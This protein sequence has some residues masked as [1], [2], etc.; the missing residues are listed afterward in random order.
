M[1]GIC[2]RDFLE[3]AATGAAA[4]ALPGV[5]AALDGC[6]GSARRPPN[7][8]FILIDDMGW[9]DL[10]SYGSDLYETPNIDRLASQGMRFTNAYAASAV[11]SPTRASIMTGKYPARLDITD[12]IGGS[13][14]GRLLPAE[15]QHELPLEEVTIAEAFQNAGYTTGYIGKW[16]LGSDGYHPEDQGFGLNIGGHDAGQPSS[17]FWPYRRDPDI[18]AYWDVPD[19]EDGI[20]GEYLTDRLTREAVRFIEDNR[21]HPFLLYLAHYAV[22]T[23]IQ[24]KPE[25]TEQYQRKIE[26]M[27]Q[28]DGPD[29]RTE[30]D[31]WGITNLRQDDPAYAGMVQS[32]DESVGRLM[33]T[34]EEIGESDNTIII[35]MSDNGGLTTY[36]RNAGAPTAVLPLRAGKG[37]YYEGGIREPLIIRWPARVKAGSVCHEPVISTDFYPT[38]LEMAGLPPRPDQHRDGL[39]LMPLLIE[40]G[41]LER[42]ALYWHSPH[43]HGSGNRPG[44][45]M[46]A[47]DWKLIE[48]FEDGSLELYNLKEDISEEHD[49]SAEMP[50][51]AEEMRTMLAAWRVEMDAKMPRPNPDFVLPG[52][53]S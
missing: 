37:W 40:A 23:P 25:L 3:K 13:Q 50:G 38:M 39:S 51:K 46:R 21:D 7:F 19:L 31:G 27:P 20:E 33:D 14:K 8:V 5:L 12:W 34:L 18:D 2:R 35:F 26:G 28:L 52:G 44:G 43:Y 10:G 17:Y 9:T 15:Y 53:T 42:E 4:A 22:H 16:H 11:C 45:A 24:S 36:A 6:S 49:L 41:G 1:A 32:V 48:W 30:H 47:G 29:Y